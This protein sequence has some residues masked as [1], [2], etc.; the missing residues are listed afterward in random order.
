MVFVDRSSAFAAAALLSWGSAPLPL[1]CRGRNCNSC[2]NCGFVGTDKSCETQS[3]NEAVEAFRA[4]AVELARGLSTAFGYLELKSSA[5]SR[6]AAAIAAAAAD[7]GTAARL[8]ASFTR[9]V[10]ELRS[11]ARRLGTA[12]AGAGAREAVGGASTVAGGE[13]APSATSA[14]EGVALVLEARLRAVADLASLRL[15]EAAV[16]A[17]SGAATAPEPLVDSDSQGY[18]RFLLAQSFTSR[19]ACTLARLLLRK[20][21]PSPQAAASATS[22]LQ[23]RVLAVKRPLST[24]PPSTSSLDTVQSVDMAMLTALP[25]EDALHARI[26]RAAAELS[27]M[28]E[29]IA[30]NLVEQSSE[31]AFVA[32]SAA[33]SRENVLLGN[34]ELRQVQQR[35]SFLRDAVIAILLIM[36][37]VILFLDRWSRP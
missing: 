34:S 12:A 25:A 23:P 27:G 17:A 8:A 6:N 29:F 14:D 13:A 7:A 15:R 28:V 11:A 22:S 26:E 2:C 31:V 36:T 33:T 37:A 4:S 24:L 9:K 18:A 20:D 32:E 30:A 10:T 1:I 35:P 21:V 16:A 3:A 19:T 5:G